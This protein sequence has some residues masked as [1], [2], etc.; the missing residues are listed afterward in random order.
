MFN[1]RIDLERCNLLCYKYLNVESDTVV[2]LTD[3]NVIPT[4]MREAS[5]V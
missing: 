5:I 2:L 3:K 4:D 1:L